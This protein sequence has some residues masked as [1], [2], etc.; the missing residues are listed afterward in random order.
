MNFDQ[1]IEFKTLRLKNDSI[2]SKKKRG[3]DDMSSSY[4]SL[5]LNF[6]PE[7]ADRV[8]TFQGHLM[9]HL[10]PNRTIHHHDG[11]TLYYTLEEVSSANW[12][13]NHHNT[14]PKWPTR[15]AF[16]CQLFQALTAILNQQLGSFRV[17]SKTKIWHQ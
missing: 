3:P 6:L 11:L 1:I 13:Y 17:D 14:T 4:C 5:S 15:L 8:T 12:P 16:R 7:K 9:L 10:S 2:Y